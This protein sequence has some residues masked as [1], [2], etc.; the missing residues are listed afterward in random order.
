MTS[1]RKLA[2]FIGFVLLLI[3]EESTARNSED[4]GKQISS[5]V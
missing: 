2:V 4:N 1:L 3:L 5:L